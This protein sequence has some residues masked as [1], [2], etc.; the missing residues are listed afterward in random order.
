MTK[1]A[2]PIKD[3]SGLESTIEEHFGRA[4]YFALIETE[5]NKVSHI[6]VVENPFK[7]HSP[8]VLPKFLKE[9]GVEV[10]IVDRI[11]PR[12]KLFFE[13]FS[14]KVLEGYKGRLRDII[15]NIL[16]SSV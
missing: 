10:V 12:A 4:K 5:N 8:G 2:A 16:K 11:G 6:E 9:K 14:I 15:E 7:E 3:K 1:I 13:S